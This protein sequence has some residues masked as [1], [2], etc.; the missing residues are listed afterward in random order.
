FAVGSDSTILRTQDGGFSW[1]KL[2]APQDVTL[3]GVFVR[4]NRNAVIVGSRGTILWTDNAGKNWKQILTGAKDHLYGVSFAPQQPE[5]GWATGTY[6]R[7]LKTTDG[8]STW[9]T[10][11]SPTREHILKISALD[12]DHAAAAGMNGTVLTTGDGGAKW[13]LT[14][15]CGT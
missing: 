6:G 1:E 5:T 15:P 11:S 7:I 9:Q 14:D 13:K 12:S 10:Q 3:S 8:G 2:S 4:D